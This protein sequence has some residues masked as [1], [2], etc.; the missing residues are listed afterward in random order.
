[1]NEPI[2]GGIMFPD[3][4]SIL[5]ESSMSP[6]SSS[7]LSFLAIPDREH[8]KGEIVINSLTIRVDL[9]GKLSPTMIKHFFVWW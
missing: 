5:V 3:I 9:K 1:M 8:V 7:V 2:G 4:L 6:D